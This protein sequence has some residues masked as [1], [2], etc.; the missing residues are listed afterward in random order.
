MPTPRLKLRRL[1]GFKGIDTDVTLVHRH[2]KN[3]FTISQEAGFTPGR[4]RLVVFVLA[5]PRKSSDKQTGI[6]GTDRFNL[7][8]PAKIIG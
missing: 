8:A 1:D 4:E 3:A 5:N 7:A 2:M 6:S